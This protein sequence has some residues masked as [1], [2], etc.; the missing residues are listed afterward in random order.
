MKPIETFFIYSM[1]MISLATMVL[2]LATA[3]IP[4]TDCIYNSHVMGII[5]FILG[6][7]AFLVTRKMLGK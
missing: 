4:S 7:Q 5:L 1:Y 6:L 3:M 2:G